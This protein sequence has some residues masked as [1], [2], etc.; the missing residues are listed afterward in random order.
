MLNRLALYLAFLCI[1]SCDGERKGPAA[2]PAASATSS[3]SM[4]GQVEKK[5]WSK[6]TESWHA[7][8]SDYFVINVDGQSIILRPSDQVSEADLEAA[9]GKTVR[10]TGKE[11][12]YEPYEPKH[13][14]EQYPTGPDGKPLPRGGG[15]RVLSLDIVN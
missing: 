6:S 8:G 14:G 3:K 11:V 10:V 15:I 1:A 2:Q 12:P 13:P 4:Q 5:P 9:V 7:G